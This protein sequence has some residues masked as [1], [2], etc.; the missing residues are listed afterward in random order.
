MWRVVYLLQIATAPDSVLPRLVP[1]ECAQ[2]GGDEIVVCR[3]KPDSA[4]YGP[5]LPDRTERLLPDAGF[6]L[7]GARAGLA[8]EQRSLGGGISVPAAM[9]SVKI[10]F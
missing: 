5:R 4:R 9:A 8:G 10:P 2:G 1:P 3:A 7:F 6:R